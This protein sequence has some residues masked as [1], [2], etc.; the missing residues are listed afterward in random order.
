MTCCGNT[1]RSSAAGALS[2]ERARDP[3]LFEYDGKAPLTL[4]GQKTGIRYHFP[5][6]GA[7]VYVDPRDRAMF[8]I[9]SG[10]RI[11]TQP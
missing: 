3:A 1:I 2:K 7:R 5:G 9:I 8:E 10:M 6:P 4:F 11:V